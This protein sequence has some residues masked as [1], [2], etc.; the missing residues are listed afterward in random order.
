VVKNSD[1]QLLK[2]AI[3]P[4]NCCESGGLLPPLPILIS[5]EAQYL[6]N[7]FFITDD[8]RKNFMNNNQGMAQAFVDYFSEQNVSPSSVAYAAWLFEYLYSNQSA[9]WR[10]FLVPDDFGLINHPPANP[11]E[12]QRIDLG[13]TITDLPSTPP[14]TPGRLIGRTPDRHPGTN[15]P[16]LQHSFNGDDVG[17]YTHMI[18]K[19]DTE[20][21]VSMRNLFSKCTIMSPELR[22]VAWDM[23]SRFENRTGG[24]YTNPTLTRHATSCVQFYNF[25]QNFG[26]RLGQALTA[27]GGDINAVT[28]INTTSIRPA[29]TGIWNTLAGLKILINDT[30]SSEIRLIS[31]TKDSGINWTAE[32]EVTIYDNF[33]L[34][35]PDV[36]KY[37]GK[38]E[39]FA[40][41]YLLQHSRNYVPFKTKIVTRT[42]IQGRY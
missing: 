42:K 30:E 22:T 9:D 10:D 5:P 11:V 37:Q 3:V 6:I 38:H 2:L 31:F 41:W 24:E 29:Y 7:L 36:L 17:V 20:L 23:I 25:L 26:S 14:V 13:I 21:F 16:D 35:K 40:A 8:Q 32:I 28:E 15:P 4:P 19:T 12:E 27:T 34:D 33:G 18:P 39:G 1:G